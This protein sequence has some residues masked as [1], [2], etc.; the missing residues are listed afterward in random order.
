MYESI[1]S[2]KE[3]LMYALLKDATGGGKDK[4]SIYRRFC[5]IH[6]DADIIIAEDGELS[7]CEKC[8]MRCKNI[9]RHQAS[10]T[11]EKLS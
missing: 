11:C 4:F 2:R 8:G 6:P 5:Y 7:K 3:L 1:T 10:A 9:P